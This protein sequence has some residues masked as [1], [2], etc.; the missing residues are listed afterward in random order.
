MKVHNDVGE[1]VMETTFYDWKQPSIIENNECSY[2]LFWSS[3]GIWR[4][5]LSIPFGQTQGRLILISEMWLRNSQISHFAYLK[6]F[7]ERV[8]WGLLIWSFII[9]RIWTS[10]E[11]HTQRWLVWGPLGLMLFNAAKWD[12]HQCINT[13]SI[14]KNSKEKVVEM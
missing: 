12:R 6:L 8:R 7:R 11:A 14:S 13:H 4:K 9:L 5:K 10:C 2:M 1:A 3:I